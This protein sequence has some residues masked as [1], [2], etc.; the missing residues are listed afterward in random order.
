[1]NITCVKCH[2]SNII[3][4]LAVI[5][6]VPTESLFDDGIKDV[7]LRLRS[8]RKDSVRDNIEAKVCAD[9]GFIE[10][11]AQNPARLF[12]VYQNLI[13]HADLE[14]KEPLQEPAPGIEP[15]GPGTAL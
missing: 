8:F 6:E 2:S 4:S 1:M 11:Y 9:C 10:F 3:T 13:I 7:E 12:E 5:V 14:Q 15:M